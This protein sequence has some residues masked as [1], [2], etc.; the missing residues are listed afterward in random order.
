MARRIASRISSSVRLMVAS[1]VLGLAL[2]VPRPAHA[3][4]AG[5]WSFDFGP[6]VYAAAI[7]LGLYVVGG[8]ITFLAVDVNY[9]AKRRQLPVG[10]AIAQG[11]YGSSFFVTGLFTLQ[12]ADKIPAATLMAIGGTVAAYPVLDW[13]IRAGRRKV[14]TSLRLTPT[15]LLASGTF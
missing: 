4:S 6:G 12:E 8:G 7:G 11:I 15:G 9:A 1:A 3:Q 13:R 14:E 5:Q 10:W 2:L